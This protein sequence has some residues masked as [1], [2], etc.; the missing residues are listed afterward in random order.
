MELTRIARAAVIAVSL[1]SA[2]LAGTAAA[3]AAEEAAPESRQEGYYYPKLTS[4]EVYKARAQTMPGVDRR[5]RLLFLSDMAKEQSTAPYQPTFVL[6]AKGDDAEKLILIGMQDGGINT[7]YRARAVLAGL[8]SM[9]RL[10]PFFKETKV[11]DVLTFLDLMKLLGFTQ[12]TLSDGH[13]F[14]HRITIQ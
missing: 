7:L 13:S 2:G 11:E 5:S 12:L 1:V 4:R 14:S 9:A 10:T 3:G 8:S 6:F